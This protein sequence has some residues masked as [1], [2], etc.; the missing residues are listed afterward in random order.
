MSEWIDGRTASHMQMYCPGCGKCLAVP[1]GFEIPE[2]LKCQNCSAQW[3]LI[4]DSKFRA[5]A[6]LYKARIALSKQK[7]K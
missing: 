1:E 4:K 2:L 6:D 3:V 7:E 5:M